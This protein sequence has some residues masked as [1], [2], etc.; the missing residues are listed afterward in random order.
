VKIISDLTIQRKLVV[1]F[2]VTCLAVVILA[3]VATIA[4]SQYAFRQNM[5]RDL[6][7]QAQMAADNCRAAVAF[8][9]SQTA[10]R[11]LESFRAKPSV[12][13]VA[14]DTNKTEQFAAYY[15]KGMEKQKHVHLERSG[16][17]FTRNRIIVQEDI[18]LDGEILGRIVL[19]SD[20]TQLASNL[21]WNTLIIVSVF[22]FASIIGYLLLSRLQGLISEPILSLT[23]VAREVSLRKDYS[24]R[25][26]KYYNDEVGVLIEAFNQM[27][28]QIQKEMSERQRAEEELRKHRDHLEEVVGERTGELKLAAFSANLLA[29]QAVQANKSKGEFLANMSHEIRTPMNAI[30]GF[31]ELLGEENLTPEQKKYVDVI[32]SS[33]KGLLRIINDILDF[34]KIEAGK[35]KTEIMDCA[36]VQMLDEIESL[37]RPMCKQ[38]N[39]D[40][41]VLYCSELPQIIRTDPVRLRQCLVNLLGNAIKFTEKGHVYLNVGLETIDGTSF[42]RFDVEDTGIGVPP[43]KQQV[44]FDPFTQADGSHTRRFGGTGLGLT[45]TKQIVELL[46]GRI[47]VRSESG[48]GAVFTIELPVGAEVN[49]QTVVNRY[50]ALEQLQKD[51]NEPSLPVSRRALVAEDAKANQA[52]IQVLLQKMGFEVTIV[53]DGQQAIEQV[54]KKAFDIIFMDM[55]MPVVNGYDATQQIKAM[56]IRTPVIAVTAHAMKGDEQKCFDAGCDDY[57]AKPI[58]R[59]KMEQII[60]E[61]LSKKAD[62][63]NVNTV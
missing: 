38:K 39:L 19:C 37:F 27:L 12:V 25:A 59:K 40:F 32:L 35:L 16:W 1:I 3:G 28:F 34:S 49:Q 9:D 51:Q 31:G 46:G 53:E 55:Q 61:H 48:R 30:L 62:T 56:G 5:I 10:S 23:E 52:L 6:V 11:S 18:I 45:I 60:S 2:T 22:V 24:V 15:R 13:F 44:I 21:R 36:L 58:D 26:V 20:L 41:D 8:E 7:I 42:V 43:E 63:P 57:I 33:G 4:W 47:Y 50:D 29:K 54:R 17:Q 14:I